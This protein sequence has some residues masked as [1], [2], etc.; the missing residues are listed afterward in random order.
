[1][2]PYRRGQGK[3]LSLD[4]GTIQTRSGKTVVSRPWYHTGAV[5]QNC[6]LQTMVPYR[7]GQKKLLSLDHGAIQTRSGKTVVS[8][9]WYH[10]DAVR[11]NCCL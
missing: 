6:C 5:R 3:L 8:R 7:R 1:M 2:V 9:P 11:E 10:T 4:H